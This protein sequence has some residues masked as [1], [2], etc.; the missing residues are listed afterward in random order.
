LPRLQVL[1]RGPEGSSRRCW[2]PLQHGSE[3][4]FPGGKADRLSVPDR[5]APESSLTWARAA[6][7]TIQNPTTHPAAQVL[8]IRNREGM[9]S[10]IYADDLSPLRLFSIR[11][12]HMLGILERFVKIILIVTTRTPIGG[13]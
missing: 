8:C 6:S 12:D 4:P 5:T 9:R 10:T 3:T 7:L 11:I 1:G 13:S 2:L